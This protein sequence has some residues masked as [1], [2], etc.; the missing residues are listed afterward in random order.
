MKII[1]NYL[2]NLFSKKQD[3]KLQNQNDILFKI[4]LKIE[5]LEDLKIQVNDY[6]NDT[7]ED[8][9]WL[10]YQNILFPSFENIFKKIVINNFWFK[11]TKFTEDFFKILYL[12]QKKNLFIIID[13]NPIIIIENNQK[14]IVLFKIFMI[15]DHIYNILNKLVCI[16]V[17]ND[18]NYAK[19]IIIANLLFFIKKI[20]NKN[21]DLEKII[22]NYAHSFEVNYV[23]KRLNSNISLTP[24]NEG[25][26][27]EVPI[28]LVGIVESMR[29]ELV[30]IKL[31]N[32]YYNKTDNCFALYFNKK[33]SYKNLKKSL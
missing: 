11:D 12:I 18:E 32:K 8:L 29:K 22:E 25:N 20:E 9:N 14:E 28:S 24:K 30:E 2:K 5:E 10:N 17:S 21:A 31:S 26:S 6:I 13:S 27:V 7:K 23:L 3:N 16:N 33:K 19:C 1:L 15:Y 4:K